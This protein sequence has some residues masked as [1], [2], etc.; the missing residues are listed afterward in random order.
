MCK[1][2]YVQNNPVNWVD[3]SGHCTLTE[4][5]VTTQIA[6]IVNTMAVQS[7]RDNLTRALGYGVGYLNGRAQEVYEAVDTL[8]WAML[9]TDLTAAVKVGRAAPAVVGSVWK[10]AGSAIAKLSTLTPRQ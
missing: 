8:Q 10:M 2:T 5:V 1:Y 7:G 4:A 3:P 6:S 9:I